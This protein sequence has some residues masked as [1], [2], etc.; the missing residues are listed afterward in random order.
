M[1]YNAV[2]DVQKSEGGSTVGQFTAGTRSETSIAGQTVFT[3]SNV[4]LN[5]TLLLFFIDGV[6]WDPV[7]N[8]GSLTN[9]KT[10]YFN[11]ATGFVTV[12]QPQIDG[13]IVSVLYVA[14]GAGTVQN[15]PV[16]VQE[17]KNW[18]R[19]DLSDDDAIITMLI[20]AAREQLESYTNISFIRRVVTTTIM[21]QLGGQY[22]PYGP[23]FDVLY[24]KDV[25]GKTVTDYALSGVQFKQLKTCFCDPVTVQYNAGYSTLPQDFKSALL[26]QVAFLFENRGDAKLASGLSTEA[27][28]LMN[29]YRRV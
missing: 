29:K 18:A 4:M 12:L 1:N 21:N 20:T 17:V 22:L 26:C 24:L 16:T 5:G 28:L 10:Y 23:V 8:I 14:T 25:D 27:V 7:V 19:I 13:V 3:F 6:K 11:T 2:L 15:E 9:E